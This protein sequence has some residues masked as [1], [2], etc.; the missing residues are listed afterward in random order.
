[1]K[2]GI[3]AAM[4]EELKLLVENLG[5]KT[6]QLPHPGCLLRQF[7]VSCLT[8]PIHCLR[9]EAESWGPEGTH[10]L[11]SLI[12]FIFLA[13]STCHLGITWQKGGISDQDEKGGY[14]PRVPVF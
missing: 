5:D 10:W 8:C 12:C 1:M 3:I 14:F 7:L 4:E 9:E 2:I 6:K 13:S 11:C